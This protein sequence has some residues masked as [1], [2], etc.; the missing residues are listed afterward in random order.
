MP[1]GERR[2]FAAR[3][4]TWWGLLLVLAVSGA[5]LA[6]LGRQWSLQAQRE[7]EAELR[8]RGEQIRDAIA[9]YRGAREPAAWPESLEALLV[10]ER[11]RFESDAAS[12]GGARHHLRRLW[13]DPFTG[14][15]DWELLPAPPPQAGFVGV[16]SRSTAR[17]LSQQGVPAGM[18]EGDAE[19][20]V[21]DWR[22]VH[23]APDARPPTRTATRTTTRGG[24]NP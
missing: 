19:P 22:F 6:A 4:F 23:A 18:G 17:R 10:D 5:A 24:S 21:S 13:T 2:R 20:R 15:A 7:R 9:R 11:G 12:S 3:G 14:S 8:F 1:S 16:R